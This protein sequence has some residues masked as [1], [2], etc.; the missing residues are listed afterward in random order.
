MD[1]FL[2]KAKVRALETIAIAGYWTSVRLEGGN[3]PR[4]TS[5]IIPPANEVEKP[6]VRTPSRSILLSIA[7]RLPATEKATIPTTFVTVRTRSNLRP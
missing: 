4:R 7:L 1:T 2:K 3:F 6:R 5:A